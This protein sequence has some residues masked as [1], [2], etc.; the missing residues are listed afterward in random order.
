M[1]SLNIHGQLWFAS[2]FHLNSDSPLTSLGFINLTNEAYNS[3]K[4]LFLLGDIFEIWIGD[5]ILK[6]ES[7]WMNDILSSLKNLTKK[8]PVFFVRGNRD[9]LIGDVFSEETG[10]EIIKSQ[11][12]IHNDFKS[13][14][15]THGDELCTNDIEYQKLRSM[16]NNTEWQNSFLKKNIE[17]RMILASNLREHSKTSNKEKTNDIMD[18][19]AIEVSNIFKRNNTPILIHGHTHKPKKEYYLINKIIYE[20]WVLPEWNLEKNNTKNGKIIVDKNGISYA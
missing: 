20:R 3:A 11:T 6:Y 12:I 7:K 1:N 16:V 9:F 19:D 10:I 17:E 15:I 4:A 18:V 8:I 2:D 5:D 14:T 13:I